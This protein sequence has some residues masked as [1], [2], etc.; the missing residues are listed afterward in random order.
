MAPTISL[1]LIVRDEEAHLAECL[2]PYRDLNPEI[3]VVDTGSVD[4]TVA[5]ARE[6]GARVECRPWN[7][8]FAAARNMSLRMCTGAWIFVV[9]ADERVELGDI[10]ALVDLLEGPRATAYRFITR[11]YTGNPNISGFCPVADV[12]PL[13][14]GFPGWFPSAKVRLFP[15][16]PRVQFEGV[17]HELVNPSLERAGYSIATSDI[18]IHHYSLLRSSEAIARK[19]QLYIDLGVEKIRRAP[20]DPK[21]H[22]ELANQYADLGNYP[23]AATAYRAALG[24]R[25]SDAEAL[26]DLGGVL[27]LM[28]HDREAQTA[29]ELAVRL[30]PDMHEGWRNLGVVHGAMNEWLRAVRCFRQ[31]LRLNSGWADGHRFLSIALHHAGLAAEAAAEARIAV[32]ALPGSTEAAHHYIEI[33]KA[34]G[35]ADEARQCLESLLAGQPEARGWRSGL[36]RFQ[37]CAKAPAPRP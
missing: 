3:C 13:A 11:N 25:P 30:K 34:L 32:E 26:K 19:Y 9:D 18:P 15:N 16:D 8:D 4:G 31:A 22:L 17:V 21:A 2:A 20:D 28:G 35:R 12:E 7:N 33:L 23:A 5:L 6:L 14:R 36:D 10:P 24:L 37:P 1:A 29:L 27:H